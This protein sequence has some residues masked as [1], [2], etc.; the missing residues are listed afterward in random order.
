MCVCFCLKNEF[1]EPLTDAQ[2]PQ[3]ST[4][5]SGQELDRHERGWGDGYDDDGGG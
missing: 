3:E 1:I 2:V 4:T 5:A